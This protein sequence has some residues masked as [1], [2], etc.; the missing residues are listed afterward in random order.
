MLLTICQIQVFIG[1]F[2]RFMPSVQAERPAE[3]RPYI[4]FRIGGSCKS[5]GIVRTVAIRIVF[6]EGPQDFNKLILGNRLPESSYPDD[7]T[8]LSGQ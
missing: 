8:S 2:V 6:R 5:I 4:S 7:P 3:D 1:T